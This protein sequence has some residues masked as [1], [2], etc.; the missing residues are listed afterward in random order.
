MISDKSVHIQTVDGKRNTQ[1]RMEINKQQEP[2][3][4]PKTN[5]LDQEKA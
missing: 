4:C 3:K 2:L 1:T 5:Y